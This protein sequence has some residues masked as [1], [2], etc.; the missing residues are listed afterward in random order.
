[1]SEKEYDDEGKT[2]T[3]ECGE[4]SIV[5]REKE[6]RDALDDRVVTFSGGAY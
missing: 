5:R 2:M 1:M 3:N 4:G 6:A